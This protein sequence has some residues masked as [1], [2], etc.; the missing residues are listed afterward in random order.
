MERETDLFYL[1][2]VSLCAP[3]GNLRDQANV[4]FEKVVIPV[5]IPSKTSG[6]TVVLCRTV[7]LYYIS[8]D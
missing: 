7:M 3:F 5:V 1:G 4:L 8:Y 2:S 6:A